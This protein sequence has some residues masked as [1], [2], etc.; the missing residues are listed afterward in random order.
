MS[1]A[2]SLEQI[3][4]TFTGRILQPA[5]S[6]YDDARRVHNGLI[7][8]RPAIIARCHGTADVADA[9]KLARTLEPRDRRPRRRTQRRRTRNHRR[10]ADDRSRANEGHSRQ[11]VHANGA[12]SGRRPVEGAQSRDAAPRSRND[13]RRGR[14][15][16]HRRPDARRRPRLVD[17]EVRPRA[18][19]PEV[20]GNGDGR[21]HG[22]PRGG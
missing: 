18:R 19:Q 15:D 2:A 8:K 7:D 16:R 10:R 11:S 6:G 9:V 5:D 12:R 17:A 4:A 14:H 1:V 21:R 3:T 22:P 13:R 20:R